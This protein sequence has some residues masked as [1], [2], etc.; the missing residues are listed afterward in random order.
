MHQK[1]ILQSRTTGRHR[2]GD[3]TEERKPGY[4]GRRPEAA[5]AQGAPRLTAQSDL[6]A[7]IS[8]RPIY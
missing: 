6:A 4:R 7:S 8:T 2:A 1:S 5:A 3:P